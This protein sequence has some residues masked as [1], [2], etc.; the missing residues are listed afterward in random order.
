MRTHDFRDILGPL[1]R[2]RTPVDGPGELLGTLGG[3]DTHIPDPGP[4]VGWHGRVL[5]DT[6]RCAGEDMT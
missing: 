1:G 3:G 6:E 2:T 4:G 5:D